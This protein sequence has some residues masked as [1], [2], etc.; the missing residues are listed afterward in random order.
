MAGLKVIKVLTASFCDVSEGK[1]EY[2]LK[3]I[4]ICCQQ[5]VKDPISA[6]HSF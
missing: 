1:E 6:T 5:S 2:T 4:W 3:K